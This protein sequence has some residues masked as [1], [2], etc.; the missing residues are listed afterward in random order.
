MASYTPKQTRDIGADLSAAGEPTDQGM[1]DDARFSVSETQRLQG[2]AQA[3]ID[4][5]RPANQIGS[6]P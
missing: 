4:K 5:T 3:R 1:S 2:E 6:Q